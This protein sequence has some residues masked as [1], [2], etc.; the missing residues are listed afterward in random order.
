[1]A[2][3]VEKVAIV[4]ANEADLLPET[5]TGATLIRSHRLRFARAAIVAVLDDLDKRSN[6]W[7]VSW[8][9]LIHHFTE[10]VRLDLGLSSPEK[11]GDAPKPD[12]GQPRPTDG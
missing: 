10:S 9:G 8:P 12:S 1:M 2:D 3:L 7:P 4:L 5:S 11:P 6:G